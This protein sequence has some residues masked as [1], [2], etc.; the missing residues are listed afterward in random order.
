MAELPLAICLFIQILAISRKGFNLLM[1]QETYQP[2]IVI[3]GLR[4][5]LFSR[6]EAQSEQSLFNERSTS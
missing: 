5:L 4:N 3:D 2:Q 1:T 6:E